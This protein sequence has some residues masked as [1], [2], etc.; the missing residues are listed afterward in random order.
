MILPI[1]SYGDPVLRSKTKEIPEDFPGLSDLIDSMWETMYKANGVGLAAPQISKSLRLFLVDTMST[2]EDEEGSGIKKAFINPEILSETGDK[3]GFE[4]GCL[5]IPKIR[6][7]VIR[8]EIVRIKYF[9]E[10]FKEFEETYDGMNA[11]V[12]QH[13]Y[14]HIEGILF[15]DHLKP[16]KKRLLRSKLDAISKGKIEIDYKMKFPK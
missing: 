12:I 10:H 16:L 13:E 3:W 6:E 15:T 2:Y 8:K 4:E 11:R 9:D 7:E 1:V 5:S 14:D